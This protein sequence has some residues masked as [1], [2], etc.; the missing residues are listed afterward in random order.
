MP[1]NSTSLNYAVTR[2]PSAS[3]KVSEAAAQVKQQ[4]SDL[5]SSAAE[6]IDRN[7][8]TAASGLE[9]AAS[10]LHENAGSIPGG[11]KVADLAHATADKLNSTAEYVREHDVS[12]MMADIERLVRNNPGPSLLAAAAVGFLVGRG[13]TDSD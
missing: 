9:K 2:E 10:A 1:V 7:R 8:G 5:G 6:K 3:E 12:G 13:F 4:V 11:E